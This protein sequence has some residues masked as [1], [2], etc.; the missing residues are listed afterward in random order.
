MK[1]SFNEDYFERGISTGLS[2]YTNYRWIPELTIPMCHEMAHLLSIGQDDTILDFGCSKGYV[3]KGFRLLGFEAFGVDVSEYAIEHSPEDVRQFLT[4]IQPGQELPLH[5]GKDRWKWGISKDVLEH[6]DYLDLPAAVANLRKACERAY[7]VVPLGDGL[8]YNI[9]SYEM[10][11][12]HKI[13]EALGWWK[14]IFFNAGWNIN[15]A[16]YR[17]GRIK[18]NWASTPNGNGFFVLS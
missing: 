4:L 13:R 2:L 12:T 10:D 16:G 14:T 5:Q 11:V 9:P 3:V 7:I 1:S 8:K 18:D 6:I 17:H 15:Y